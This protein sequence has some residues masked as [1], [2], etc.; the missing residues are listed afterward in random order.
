MSCT[1]ACVHLQSKRL[2]EQLRMQGPAACRA[3]AEDADV[4]PQA[5]DA[6]AKE[7]KSVTPAMTLA[8]M[9]QLIM[10]QHANSLGI[11]FGGQV[12]RAVHDLFNIC[13]L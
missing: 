4:A 5:A 3:C 12:G 6:G 2:L 9:T 10:P 13:F 8:H 1:S 11:T 7:K